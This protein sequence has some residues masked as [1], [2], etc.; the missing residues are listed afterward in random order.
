MRCFILNVPIESRS[1]NSEINVFEG[2]DAPAKRKPPM[3]TQADRVIKK[4]GGARRLAEMLECDA[5]TIYKWTYPESK[6]GT[7]GHIPGHALR[8]IIAL[9]R[10][11]GILLTDEDLSLAEIRELS[12]RTKR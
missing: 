4:F 11:N 10:P 7:G 1:M 8:R 3:T 12:P 5:S 9:A 2:L 6:Q